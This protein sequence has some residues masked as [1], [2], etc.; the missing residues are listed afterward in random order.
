MT[1][2]FLPMF[3]LAAG[4]VA[5]AQTPP[6]AAQQPS[7]DMKHDTVAVTGCVAEGSSG[8]FMLNNA[9]MSHDIKSGTS[10]SG[11]TPPTTSGTPSNSSM[12][13]SYTLVGGENLKAHVGHKVEVTG[14]MG[15]SGSGASTSGTAGTTGTTGTGMKAQELRVQSVKMVSATC[16]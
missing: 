1:R 13:S 3:V 11:T 12:T 14:T 6:P 15:T 16:P 9:M 2:N 10:T 5:F 7:K 8:T 4:A